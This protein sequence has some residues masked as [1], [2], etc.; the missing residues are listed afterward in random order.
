[1]DLMEEEQELNVRFE[2]NNHMLYNRLVQVI[3]SKL[4]TMQDQILKDEPDAEVPLTTRQMLQRQTQEQESAL[5]E[6]PDHTSMPD[7]VSAIEKQRKGL[8]AKQKRK[9]QQN[10]LHIKKEGSQMS[11][12]ASENWILSDFGSD[13]QSIGG[14]SDQSLG[15]VA[16]FQK[17][18]FKGKLPTQRYN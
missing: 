2:F 12:A 16:V 4:E 17:T 11:M 9:K 1:M 10:M 7:Y 5:T 6:Y 14:N 18:R 3:N 8:L 15:G 13:A